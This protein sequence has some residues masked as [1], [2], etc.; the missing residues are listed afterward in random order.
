MSL[1]FQAVAIARRAIDRHTMLENQMTHTGFR[2]AALIVTTA[3]AATAPG[4]VRAQRAAGTVLDESTPPG[5]NYEKAEFR[6]WMPP[7]SG[8]VRG[9]L[10][11]VPGSNGD[12]RAMAEDSVWQ[13]FAARHELAIVACRYT[14]K[15][16]DQNFIEEYVN[17]S[18]GSAFVLNN[19]GENV[20]PTR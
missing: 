17:V 19:G 20:S 7:G 10:V 4:V 16:H 6:V 9:T 2:R 11:L 1:Y 14:D 18:R 13:A 15:P 5:A 8:S 3:A 12:G